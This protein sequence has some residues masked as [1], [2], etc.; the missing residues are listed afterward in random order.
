MLPLTKALKTALRA[1]ADATRAEGQQAY[2][3]SAMPY[4]G[5]RG[6][7]RV[8][9]LPGEGM[10][11]LLRLID[12]YLGTRDSGFAK[13]LVEYAEDEVAIRIEPEWFTAWDFSKRMAK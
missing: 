2:M 1:E 4:R 6:Q 10:P 7:G 3:K 9:I 5:V 8:S 13:W 11:V 12:R